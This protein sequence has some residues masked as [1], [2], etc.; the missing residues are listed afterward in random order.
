MKKD[1]LEQFQQYL[2]VERQYS[3]ATLRAYTDDLELFVKFLKENGGFTS[4][5][6]IERNDVHAFMSYLYDQHYQSTSISR[7]VSSL[8]T[9]YHYQQKIGATDQDP[10]SFIHLKRHPRPLPH[11][12]YEKE[13]Q[14]LFK[15][16][17][18]DSLVDIRDRAVLESLYAT[19]MRVSEC[20]GLKLND[21]DFDLKVMLLHGK[22]SK[23][24]YVP[25]GRY[26]EEALLRYFKQVRTPLMQKY[27]KEHSLVFINHYGD[28]LTAAGIT[29]IL[30]RIV[31]R[32]ALTVAIHPHE[33]RH[34]FATHLLNNGADLRAVQEFLGHSSLSTTQIYT[35]VTK[36]HLQQAYQ[37]YFPRA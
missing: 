20:T 23:D 29:Y 8:R 30:K 33:L 37:K 22:G 16:V 31:K 35:H 3:P 12:F 14:A 21:I 7:I 25:F 9:F 32:S 28:P 1:Q 13:M 11:F 6:E 17:S 10:F 19:G 36:E 2:R 24:R 4:L 27:H 34:T 18:S 15:A 26:C 5:N